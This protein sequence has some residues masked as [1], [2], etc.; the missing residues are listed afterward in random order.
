MSFGE[1][2]VEHGVT[3]PSGE[4]T[5]EGLLSVPAVSPSVAVVI[6]HPHP[7]YGGDMRNNVVSGLARAFQAA[8]MVTLR[9]NFRGV[10]AST[11]THDDGAGE[12]DDVTSA[13]SFL[14][15]Q[16]AAPVVAVAGYSFGAM[17]GLRAGADDPRVSKLVGVALPIVRRDPSFL[18]GVAK[19]KLLIVG[20]DDAYAPLAKFQQLVGELDEPKAAVVVEGADHF[21]AGV[22]GEIATVAAAFLRGET[23]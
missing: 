9:F 8:G 10:G 21:F 15:S 2:R 19:P 4:L 14:M 11:G 5:L 13:V 3:F 6:C 22:E 12:A 7:L 20:D 16:V 18:I 23:I 17:V 1:V